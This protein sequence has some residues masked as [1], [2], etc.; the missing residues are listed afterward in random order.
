MNQSEDNEN[1]LIFYTDGNVK[2]VSNE[3]A[4]KRLKE[5]LNDLGIQEITYHGLRHTHASV[6]LYEGVRTQCIPMLMFCENYALEKNK[7]RYVFMR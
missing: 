1:G 2:V 7:K 5:I 4:N 6:L 3:D